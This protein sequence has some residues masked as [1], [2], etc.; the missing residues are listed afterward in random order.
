MAKI[1]DIINAIEQILNTNDLSS[2]ARGKQLADEYAAICNDLNSALA[3]CRSLF[4]MGAYAE[5]RR[6]NLKAKPALTERFAILNFPRRAEWVSLCNI[7]SWQVPPVL[8]SETARMLTSGENPRELTIEELQNRWRK[9]IRDGSLQE[10]LILA[11]KIYALDRSPVWRANLQ[12]V[13]RPYVNELIRKAEEAFEESRSEELVELFNELISPELLQKVPSYILDKFRPMV[14][15]YNSGI[16]EKTKQEILDEIA[17]HYMAMDLKYLEKALSRWSALKSNPIFSSTEAEERQVSEARSFLL[18]KLAEA[19]AEA[20]FISLQ[21]QLELLLNEEGNPKE[22]DRIY[23]SLQQLDRPIKKLIE[24]RMADFY[25]RLALDNK[26]KHIR[27]CVAWG[28]SAFIIAV[29]IFVSIFHIQGEKELRDSIA[30]MKK[31]IADN[32]F[33][34]AAEYYKK[35]EKTSP[36]VAER[37]AM[38]ALYEEALEKQEQAIIAEKEFN[39]KCTELEKFYFKDENIN[40]PAIKEIFKELEELSAILPQDRKTIKSQLAVRYE[41]RKN[42][43]IT[44]NEIKFRGEMLPL[45]KEWNQ[46]FANFNNNRILDAERK[47][48]ELE[49]RC[50]AVLNKYKSLISSA[51][52]DQWKKNIA[53]NIASFG[54]HEENR[55]TLLEKTKNL[56][57]PVSASDY[58]NSLRRDLVISSE[59]AADFNQAMNQ[60]SIDEPL[61]QIV[62]ALPDEEKFRAIADKYLSN[63]YCREIHRAANMSLNTVSFRLAQDAKL[64]ELKSRVLADYNVYELVLINKQRPYHFYFNTP[65]KDIA[66]EYNRSNDRIKS[67]QFS[68]IISN[69]KLKYNAIFTIDSSRVKKAEQQKRMQLRA[70]QKKKKSKKK[71]APYQMPFSEQVKYMSLNHVPN[72][73]FD[74]LPSKFEMKNPLFLYNRGAVDTASHHKYFKELL[75]NLSPATPEKIFSAILKTAEDKSISNFYVKIDIMKHLFSLLPVDNDP[76]Y[77]ENLAD[78]VQLLNKFSVGERGLWINPLATFKYPNDE[79]DFAK[80]FN[81]I[82]FKNRFSKILLSSKLSAACRKFMPMP[83]GVFYEENGVWRLHSFGGGSTVSYKDVMIMRKNSNNNFEL[84]AFSPYTFV[85]PIRHQDI[86]K[87]ISSNLYNGQ[88]VYCAYGM[89]SWQ[90]EYQKA[91]TELQKSGFAVPKD[92]K[93]ITWPEY[94]PVNMKN[95]GEQKN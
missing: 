68:F 90:T 49:R 24:T 29:I 79:A 7:Y 94:W 85:R 73:I 31:H 89:D 9:I 2:S 38:K 13:E 58:F 92:T 84:I 54:K 34:T 78:A 39:K 32:N 69:S 48:S 76:L 61:H 25:E 74:S 10:K 65:D 55:D 40:N 53:D 87:N 70:E 27:S 63:P 21:N 4:K 59:V 19:N 28:V 41:D 71:V 8:D 80:E 1:N 82:D 51:L 11:R 33:S 44:R 3:E 23:H 93:G 66:L 35:L 43:Y 91:V 95:F 42:A 50:N 46:L 15:S 20:Q 6:L 83:I 81:K 12:N 14:A 62:A 64:K 30:G 88:L 16:L 56:Y 75:D 67:L 22:I 47:K 5:A 17:R 36:A 60:L 45:Q 77:K 72:Q 26:R 37:A 18:E 86:D 52:Y 57:Q